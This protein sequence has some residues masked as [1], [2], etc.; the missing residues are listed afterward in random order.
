MFA[1]GSIDFAG[2]F[3][4]DTATGAQYTILA[5]DWLSSW[6]EGAATRHASAET[7]AEIIYDNIVTRYGCPLSLQSD[8]DSHFV[9]PIIHAL[10]KIL[11]IKHHL[12]TPYYLQSNRKI[13]RVVGTITTML[14]RVV[15]EAVEVET[16]V[17]SQDGGDN[18]FCVGTDIDVE[19]IEKIREGETER[20]EFVEDIDDSLDNTPTEKKKAHWAPL[21]QSV[22]WAYR[23]THYSVTGA[24]P[25]MLALG[26]E[27]RI[28]F[29]LGSLPEEC[30][31]TD[32]ER[33]KLVAARLRHL[34]DNITG[35]REVQEPRTV[36]APPKFV[37]GQRVWKRES[38]YNTKGFPPVFAPRWTGPCVIHSIWDKNV[39]KLR[40]DPVV[41]GKKVGYLKNPINGYR[42]KAYVEGELVA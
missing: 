37:R 12:S 30:Y 5:V 17:V 18:I 3:P 1:H 25:A 13:E 9:N 19:V 39:Y 32:D 38:I 27:L 8:H 33:R 6:A 4:D 14:K 29:N 42:L 7:A 31:K 11:K 22:L 2:P 28:P 34:Y 41:T 23:C 10:Y 35:L 40:T 20:V 24:S 21:L 36:E 15:Q 26:I 16:T